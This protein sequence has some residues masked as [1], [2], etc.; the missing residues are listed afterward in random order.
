[1]ENIKEPDVA[2]DAIPELAT[3]D[4]QM[5]IQLI[6][7]HLNLGGVLVRLPDFSY[8][9]MRDKN[10]VFDM[11]FVDEHL[12]KPGYL[13]RV[14]PT[15]LA[16]FTIMYTLSEKGREVAGGIYLF[17]TVEIAKRLKRSQEAINDKCEKGTLVP[18]A[19]AG[20]TRVF[21]QWNVL[22]HKRKSEPGSKPDVVLFKK[23]AVAKI[24]G[25][26][27]RGVEQHIVQRLLYGHV[28][29]EQ[30]G[31]GTMVFT[32]EQVVEYLL[33]C[34]NKKYKQTVNYKNYQNQENKN[35]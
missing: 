17:G 33:F 26:S 16:K 11:E 9:F 7:R 27:V 3:M 21:C 14:A 12:R 28:I 25:M 24:A 29:G 20:K 22:K 13:E 19:M 18:L 34:K 1:M 8:A 32:K 6:L 2:S 10:R 31:R 15:H 4:D 35:D 5:K 23:S 30:F